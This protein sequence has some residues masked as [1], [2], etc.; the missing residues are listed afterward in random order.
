MR[1]VSSKRLIVAVHLVVVHVWQVIVFVVVIMFRFKTELPSERI[2]QVLWM[3]VL[4]LVRWRMVEMTGGMACMC[5]MPIVMVVVR[6][7]VSPRVVMTDIWMLN[8]CRYWIPSA[9]HELQKHVPNLGILS[10]FG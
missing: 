6:D 3:P 10:L 2:V 8:R 7:I 1:N 4:R 5:E 9:A